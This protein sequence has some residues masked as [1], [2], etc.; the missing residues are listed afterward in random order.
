MLKLNIGLSR[1]V[2][3][4]NYGSRGAS[5]NLEIELESE[6]AGDADTLRDRVRQLFCM[7]R[8]S[9]DEELNGNGHSSNSNGGNGHHTQQSRPANGN[10]HGSHQTQNGRNGRVA[11]ASQVRALFAIA[12]RERIDLPQLV[13]DRFQVDRAED[14]SLRDASTLID[15]LKNGQAVGGRR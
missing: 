15:E 8:A 13:R 1:K 6:M 14:L 4:A 2:G 12:S 3:E 10:G 7:A 9:V 11:T 5:V